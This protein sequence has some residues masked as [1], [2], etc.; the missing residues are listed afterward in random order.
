MIIAPE[1]F[2][3]EEYLEPKEIFEQAG[4]S[5][6]TAS[7]RTGEI[8][9]SRGCSAT[10]GISLDQAS[11]EGFDAVVLVG[12]AG[13]TVY[14]ENSQVHS[15][16][17]EFHKK[18]K[19]V[20]AIC[21]SPLTLANAGLLEG[22]KATVWEDDDIIAEIKGKGANYTGLAVTIDSRIVTASGPQAAKEFANEIV[23]LLKEGEHA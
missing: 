21:I 10:A 6:A 13:A 5:V 3:D 1:G 12:G 2:R 4:F 22:R 7:T 17:R 23:E 9:G 15:L 8:K 19:V 18:G 20:A 11:E 14:F 16:L